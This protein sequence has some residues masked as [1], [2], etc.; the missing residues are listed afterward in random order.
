M[1]LIP[2]AALTAAAFLACSAAFA[3]PSLLL[4][5]NSAGSPLDTPPVLVQPPAQP[6][7]ADTPKRTDPEVTGREELEAAKREPVPED[8][9]IDPA[10]DDDD[11]NRPPDDA[12]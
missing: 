12:G 4:P 2:R 3:Q 5:N 6:R 11:A 9:S 10:R 7:T 1:S 8:E